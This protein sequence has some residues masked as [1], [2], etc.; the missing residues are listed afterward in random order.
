M[1]QQTKGRN[2]LPQAEKVKVHHEILQFV[3]NFLKLDKFEKQEAQDYQRNRDSMRRT[4]NWKEIDMQLNRRYA[5]K[6][7]S[8][9]TFFDVIIPNLLSPYPHEIIVQVQDYLQEQVP[10]QPGLQEIARQPKA[11]TKLVKKIRE[12]IKDKFE[13]DGSDIH[14]YKKITSK[15]NNNIKNCIKTCCNTPTNI[16]ARDLIINQAI[17]EEYTITPSTIVNGTLNGTDNTYGPKC[18]DE[19]QICA[20]SPNSAPTYF[21]QELEYFGLFE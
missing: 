10:L 19:I 5:T 11:V 18:K 17:R 2:T 3:C 1:K 4:I 8:Y 16:T 20:A 13:L 6:S 14:P 15:I 7:Y 9:K 21:W 12:Q